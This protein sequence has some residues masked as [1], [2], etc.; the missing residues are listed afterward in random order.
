MRFGT[1]LV[2]P[3][4]NKAFMTSTCGGVNE[5]LTCAVQYRDKVLTDWV[6]S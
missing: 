5:A 4:S 6:K 2:M 3:H 1:S